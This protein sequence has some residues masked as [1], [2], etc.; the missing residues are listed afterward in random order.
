VF[1]VAVVVAADS[2]I[3]NT[4]CLMAF[5]WVG[6]VVA[7]A[8]VVVVAEGRTNVVAAEFPERWEAGV[9]RSRWVVAAAAAFRIAVVVVAAAA[10]VV[11][12]IGSVVVAVVAAATAPL[13]EGPDN[14]RAVAVAKKDRRPNAGLGEEAVEGTFHRPSDCPCP[15]EG[16]AGQR[17]CCCFGCY[18][19]NC[20]SIAEDTGFAD[21]VHKEM[22]HS[23]S[24]R[25]CVYRNWGGGRYCCRGCC[26]CESGLDHNGHGPCCCY[27]H[28]ISHDDKHRWILV[29]GRTD[30]ERPCRCFC[31]C[32]GVGCCYRSNRSVG[33]V[34]GAAAVS[35]PSCTG[36]GCP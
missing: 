33:C 21:R 22:D 11:V 4:N 5:Q 7:V 28:E 13:A 14:E 27:D 36:S 2:V 19:W 24:H 12:A 18:D 20:V 31:R 23:P 15:W 25:F 26:C 8:A 3:R 30:H 32:A 34:V 10:G 17:C 35:P 29:S 16:E 9:G 1:A 6:V